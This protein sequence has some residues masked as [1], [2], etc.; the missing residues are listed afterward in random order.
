M[1]PVLEKPKVWFIDPWSSLGAVGLSPLSDR[2]SLVFSSL[3]N[4]RSEV[5]TFPGKTRGP[6][7]AVKAKGLFILSRPGSRRRG[8][9]LAA[10]TRDILRIF[11]LKETG[12][13][14]FFF[15]TFFLTLKSF[16][17]G[18]SIAP[19]AG[20]AWNGSAVV[21]KVV[22]LSTSGASVRAGVEQ[23]SGSGMI[24]EDIV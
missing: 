11:S 5:S 24:L 20:A 16:R 17:P 19:S 9:N 4:P 6:I 1:G 12:L 21:L 22:I 8:R 14:R 13:R 3:V 23:V 15:E 18:L 7:P 10:R 2:S